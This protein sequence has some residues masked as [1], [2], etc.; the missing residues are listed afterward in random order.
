MYFTGFIRLDGGIGRRAGFKDTA[1]VL[2]TPADGTGEIQLYAVPETIPSRFSI[3]VTHR[4][5]GYEKSRRVGELVQDRTKAWLQNGAG[6]HYGRSSLG[7]GIGRRAGFKMAV[8][9]SAYFGLYGARMG[10]SRVLC[11][12]DFGPDWAQ[13]GLFWHTSWH[14]Y[15][16][17]VGCTGRWP[18]ESHP[19]RCQDDEP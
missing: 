14:K 19:S 1:E 6:V 3:S 2:R 15:G 10:I 16:T 7:G 18:T 11:D 13:K 12:L 5:A 17:K 4:V 8:Q 9:P